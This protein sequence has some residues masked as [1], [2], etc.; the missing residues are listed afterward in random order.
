MAVGVYDAPPEATGGRLPHEP[1]AATA[2]LRGAASGPLSRFRGGHWA[3]SLFN[4]DFT[5]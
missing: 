4:K 1:V 5:E 3:I 2:W